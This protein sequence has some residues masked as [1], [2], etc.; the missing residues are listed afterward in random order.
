MTILNI[1]RKLNKVMDCNTTGKAIIERKFKQKEIYDYLEVPEQ[2]F[3]T[4]T[5]N[6]NLVIY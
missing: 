6:T 5:T 2:C 3:R 1:V 4:K